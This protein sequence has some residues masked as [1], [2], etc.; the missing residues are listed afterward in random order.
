MSKEVKKNAVSENMS[1]EEIRLIAEY[2]KLRYDSK[3]SQ[4]NMSDATGLAQSTV[5]RLEKNLH[6][7]SLGNFIK[8]LDVLGYHLEIKKN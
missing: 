6:S 1:K 3:V 5:A 4:R 2:V 8:I 7:A